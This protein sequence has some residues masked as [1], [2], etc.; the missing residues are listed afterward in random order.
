MI[1]ERVVDGI[2]VPEI[3]Q[4][5]LDGMFESLKPEGYHER[6]L[7]GRIAE[8]LWRLRRVSIYETESIKASMNRIGKDWFFKRAGEEYAEKTMGLEP[9]PFTEEA[10]DR[11]VGLRM[12]PNAV[13]TITRYEAH[14]HRIYIQTLH[15]LEALQARRRGEKVSL[16]RLDI[17]G[18]PTG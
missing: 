10:F 11:M 4:A 8:L 16:A 14:L 6:E 12:L 17:S 2:E 7:A 1:Y 15:E 3:W 18:P 13:S 5:H 9:E